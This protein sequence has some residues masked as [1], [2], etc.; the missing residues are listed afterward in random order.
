MGLM[1]T[2]KY[3]SPIIFTPISFFLFFMFIFYFFLFFS[4]Y[5]GT[6]IYSRTRR[7]HHKLSIY[8]LHDDTHTLHLYTSTTNFRYADIPR[9]CIKRH[10]C[11]TNNKTHITCKKATTT[12]TFRFTLLHLWQTHM[13]SL[14]GML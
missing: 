2:K 13:I 9:T 4:N 6:I 14:S 1:K 10:A 12:N 11:R 3:L 5:K 8:G 7:R